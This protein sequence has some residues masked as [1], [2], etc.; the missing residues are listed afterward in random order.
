MIK[1]AITVFISILL[2]I[3]AFAYFGG[4]I[5]AL[6]ESGDGFVLF[7]IALIVFFIFGGLICAILYNMYQRMKEIKE[8]EKDDISKY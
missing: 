7:A 2:C 4:I 5:F 6:I 3:F 8:E 1:R